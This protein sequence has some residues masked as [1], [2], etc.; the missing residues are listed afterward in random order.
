[1]THAVA[2]L[3]WSIGP[4]TWLSALLADR[5][6][7]TPHRP[8]LDDLDIF[9]STR[10]GG[11]SDVVLFL[12]NE[13]TGTCSVVIVR[14]LSDGFRSV[15]VLTRAIPSISITPFFRGRY[16]RAAI[17]ASYRQ[18]LEWLSC[19]GFTNHKVATRG[20]LFIRVEDTTRWSLRWPFVTFCELGLPGFCNEEVQLCTSKRPLS[21]IAHLREQV[22]ALR[23][24]PG[25]FLASCV[26]LA[27]DYDHY[28]DDCH[29]LTALLV[30]SLSLLADQCI[31]DEIVTLR[32]YVNA[33]PK[34]VRE[35]L[36]DRRTQIIFADFEASSGGW[37]TGTGLRRY[38][39]GEAGHEVDPPGAVDLSALD[40]RHIKMLR[41]FH[42][43]SA[44]APQ[45]IDSV[46]PCGVDS[47]V[48]M[49]IN[50]GAG[51]VEGGLTEESYLSFGR[52][53]VKHILLAEDLR[54]MACTRA[55]EIGL[56]PEIYLARWRA[57]C[58]SQLE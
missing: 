24:S 14:T 33:P 54:L 5:F 52:S 23:Q 43:N 22:L 30:D 38:W 45:S 35:V 32:W 31:D 8:L 7:A 11:N 57:F 18:Y 12:A 20:C 15:N 58:Q 42:C 17:E 28:D 3:E 29:R 27:N 10:T 21:S 40:L 53:V 1:M 13:S 44:F 56:N 16:Q 47:I 46:H 50:L 39:S 36:E 49:L 51:L 48:G 4:D 34:L 55:L 37:E 41:A 2:D 6:R 25:D 19:P 9:L 26:V